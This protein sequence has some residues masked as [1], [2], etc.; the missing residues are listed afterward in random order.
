MADSYRFGS[1]AGHQVAFLLFAAFSIFCSFAVARIGRIVARSNWRDP[2]GR[3]VP[4]YG[5][6][7]GVLFGGAILAVVW[8]WLWSG[9]HILGIAD[10]RV[11]LQYEMPRRERVLRTADIAGIRWRSA[12]KSTKRFVIT[13]EDGSE[14]FSMQTSVER[15]RDAALLESIRHAIRRDH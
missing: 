2:R 1:L 3:A 11:I 6:I 5:A 13:M 4:I 10:G 15:S 12:P 14:Y 9:F 7:G 8:Y